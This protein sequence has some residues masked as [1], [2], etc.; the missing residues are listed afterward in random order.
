MSIHNNTHYSREGTCFFFD[1]MSVGGFFGWLFLHMF[2]F[3]WNMGVAGISPWMVVLAVLKSIYE[4]K[5]ISHPAMFGCFCPHWLVGLM[6]LMWSIGSSCVVDATVTI[7]LC[8]GI[9]YA[10]HTVLFA[11]GYNMEE[12]DDATE[13]GKKATLLT[14]GGDSAAGAPSQVEELRLQVEDLQEQIARMQEQSISSAR[15]V[16]E[17]SPLSP[18][19]VGIPAA[20]PEGSAITEKDCTPLPEPPVYQAVPTTAEFRDGNDTRV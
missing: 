12:E 2:F 20:I 4:R 9:P 6:P 13:S 19:P 16:Q 11:M 8:V 15:F 17:Y 7:V 1:G 3:V 18:V 10:L 14:E 5:W